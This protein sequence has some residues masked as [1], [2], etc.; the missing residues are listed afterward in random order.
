MRNRAPDVSL[1]E[2]IDFVRQQLDEDS[3][4]SLRS[5]RTF[6]SASLE[7]SKGWLDRT[8]GVL[9]VMNY[10]RRPGEHVMRVSII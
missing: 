9:M 8:K 3:N 4:I 5:R 7:E 6:I 2:H 10:T 1:Y